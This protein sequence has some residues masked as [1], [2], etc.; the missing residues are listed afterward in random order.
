MD[1]E[2]GLLYNEGKT[3]KIWKIKDNPDIIIIENKKTITA[4]DD[5][6]FTKE[7]E[8]KA[9][10]ATTTTC[11][12]FEL[13]QEA[14][15]PVAYRKQISP[16]EFLAEK[17][18]MIPL[19]VVGRRFAVGSYLKRH[20]ELN[21]GK[22]ETPYRF[23]RL[24]VEFFLKTTNGK[25]VIP[26]YGKILDGLD[27]KNG[28]EDP[29]I[30]NPYE[31]EWRLFHSKKPSWD[32][33]ASLKRPISAVKVLGDDFKEKI[34]QMEN[35][36][37]KV[38]LVLEGAWNT[39]GF[40][41]IDL[42]IEFGFAGDSGRLVVA[43]VIDNDSWRLRNANWRE[44]SK[45]AFRQGEE[46]SEVEEK[47]EIVSSLINQ[48]RIPKQ[49]LIFWKGSKNDPSPNLRAPYIN[50]YEIIL[51]GHKSPKKA[52]AQLNEIIGDY[53]DGGVIVVKVGRSNG[54]GP[55]L[56]ARTNWPIIAI[57]ATIKENPEDIWSSIRMPSNVPLLTAWPEK[58]A[59]LA[60]L[61]I[62]AQKNP[63]VYMERQMKIEEFDI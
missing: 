12:I 8:S 6:S 52:I 33:E 32:S 24:V 62:L 7:F 55:L 38:F 17:C 10:H 21:P 44:L 63:R 50:T 30:T 14:C 61:N 60:A 16:T 28:E 41:F 45:E 15:I 56:A 54:L 2:R 35:I 18:K 49:V 1:Y 40:R 43:D 22:N 13:L 25:L 42:K 31:T 23:H 11:R 51:S 26:G 58:N 48:I 27:A 57:P 9:R 19:E 5:P 47:Y 20:P 29:F 39:M 46:L 37:R 53:P 59:V 4:F 34:E 3:K 36:L